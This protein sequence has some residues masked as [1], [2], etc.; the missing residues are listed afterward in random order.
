MSAATDRGAELMR[1]N[2]VTQLERPPV[3]VWPSTDEEWCGYY[4]E[5]DRIYKET[6]LSPLH[7]DNRCPLHGWRARAVKS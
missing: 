6:N 2:H 4:R 5:A 1:S 3:I 7:H